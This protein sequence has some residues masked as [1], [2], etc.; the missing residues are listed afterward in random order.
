L[1]VYSRNK[2]NPSCWSE[3]FRVTILRGCAVS[4]R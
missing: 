3:D 2:S 4:D 1:S